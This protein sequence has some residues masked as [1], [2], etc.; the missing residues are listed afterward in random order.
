[1]IPFL[2][3]KK[4]GVLPLCI[5]RNYATVLLFKQVLIQRH[6]EKSIPFIDWNGS[7]EIDSS[8]IAL[9]LAM[10]DAEDDDDED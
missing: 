10:R 7:G 5:A 1:M 3:N 2:Y 8:D 4:Y 9:T 6:R